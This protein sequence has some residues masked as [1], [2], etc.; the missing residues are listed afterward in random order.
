MTDQEKINAFA[1]RISALEKRQEK[2]LAE[3]LKLKNQP[4]A[5]LLDFSGIDAVLTEAETK[6]KEIDDLNED[7]ES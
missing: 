7:E 5:E 2:I 6:A 4:Q 3:V 1:E